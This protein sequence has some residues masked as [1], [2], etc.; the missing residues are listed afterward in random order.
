MSK[1]DRELLA[2]AG[3]TVSDA[4]ALFGRTRQAIYQGTALERDYFGI[5]E[6]SLIVQDS[7]R[8]DPARIDQVIR[9]VEANYSQKDADRI[10][11]A[12]IAYAQMRKAISDSSSIV[13]VFNGN[14]EHLLPSALFAQVIELVR[15]EK[16]YQVH[17]VVPGSWAIDFLNRNKWSIS[18][19]AVDERDDAGYLPSLLL[20]SADHVVR[21]FYFS[22]ISADELHSSEAQTLWKQFEPKTSVAT[23]DIARAVG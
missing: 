6:Q 17:F 18:E 3:L 8:K 2:A 11:P 7:M 12:R 22:R 15:L 9:F 5:E 23:A 13:V 1:R 14:L 10:L 21:A 19:G 20:T 4:E 16:P